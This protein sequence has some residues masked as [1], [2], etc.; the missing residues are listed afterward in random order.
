MTDSRTILAIDQ[1]TTSTRAILFDARGHG[2]MS[3]QEELPQIYP[4]SGWVE[5]DP[6]QIWQATLNVCHNV[7]QGRKA[8]AAIG[9]TNQRETVVVWDRKTGRAI[10][11]ALVWQDR[12]TAKTC[13]DLIEAGHEKTITDKTGLV[14]DPYFSA[15][16]IAWLLDHV[17]GA[18]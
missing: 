9:I 15:T 8:P 4:L 3:A 7:L 1:G 5:H 6:E 2:F 11:N 13:R 14:I 12:R 10:H 18:R 16:K 17:E